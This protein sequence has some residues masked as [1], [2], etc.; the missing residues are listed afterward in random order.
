MGSL[1][2]PLSR[3]RDDHSYPKD[4]DGSCLVIGTPP[5][6]RRNEALP[7]D[8]VRSILY[9]VSETRAGIRRQEKPDAST[10]VE[11]FGAIPRELMNANSRSGPAEAIRG[12]LGEG[13][14]ANGGADS[15]GAVLLAIEEERAAMVRAIGA[16]FQL[17]DLHVVTLTQKLKDPDARREF[18]DAFRAARGELGKILSLGKEGNQRHTVLRQALIELVPDWQKKGVPPETLDRLINYALAEL[19]WIVRK[20]TKQIVLFHYAREHR[21]LDLA[22]AYLDQVHGFSDSDLVGD[23]VVMPSEVDGLKLP[24]SLPTTD[25]KGKKLQKKTL[26]NKPCEPYRVAPNQEEQRVLIYPADSLEAIHEKLHRS[27]IPEHVRLDY[28]EKMMVPILA[29]A[30]ALT[31]EQTRMRREFTRFLPE[32][33]LEN[34]DKIPENETTIVNAFHQLVVLPLGQAIEDAL[35]RLRTPPPAGGGFTPGSSSGLGEGGERG[36]G[37]RA[38]GQRAVSAVRAGRSPDRM[39]V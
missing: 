4:A 1:R 30:R 35:R 36:V 27:D 19:L 16:E 15:E 11:V 21:Y 31:E 2:E 39:V 6:D 26:R 20:A 3:D 33:V 34:T 32:G 13:T 29:M 14:G 10:R 18:I 17:G 37:A 7:V 9:A 24:P 8:I 25:Q 38:G 12:A 23:Y 22:R 28:I 5:A